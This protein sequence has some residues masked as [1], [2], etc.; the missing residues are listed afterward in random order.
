MPASSHSAFT[1]AAVLLLLTA[2]TAVSGSPADSGT[3]DSNSNSNNN[4]N[5]MGMGPGPATWSTEASKIVLWGSVFPTYACGVFLNGLI[6]FVILYN[7]RTLLLHRIDFVY[8]FLLSVCMLF[9]VVFTVR[10]VVSI[11]YNFEVEDNDVFARVVAAVTSVSI[12]FI[13]TANVFLAAERYFTF[14]EVSDRQSLKYFVC[15]A[16]HNFIM[17]C[18]IVVSFILS[19]TTN[20]SWPDDP[21][22]RIIWFAVII[23]SFLLGFGLIVYLYFSTYRMVSRQLKDTLS[24][25]KMD[26]LRILLERN[27]L[28]NS[29]I[30][31]AAIIVCY[32]PNA[33]WLGVSRF[34]TREQRMLGLN[35]TY[36]LVAL[37]VIITPFL[38][39]YFV[40]PIREA[41]SGLSRGRMNERWEDDE[42]HTTY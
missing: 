19:P 28:K 12:F 41:L 29:I 24:N 25:H 30:M 35:I 13:F 6:L 5:N 16:V 36:E 15:L 17:A 39:L 9:S 10:F 4:M 21:I 8:L 22:P 26:E 23:W 18:A 32:M 38:L 1:T 42:Y 40:P 7:R 11:A 3:A 31:S 2:A 37:D 20:R 27:V 14:R 34:L 33:L